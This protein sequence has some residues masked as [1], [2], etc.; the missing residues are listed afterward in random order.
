[1]GR[2]THLLQAEADKQHIRD[3]IEVVIAAYN[4]IDA[5]LKRI[6]TLDKSN[7]VLAALAVGHHSVS[8]E[9]AKSQLRSAIKLLT[10]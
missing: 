4:A 9:T 8:P 1:M 2:F 10:D 7:S 3:S 5:E 6:A